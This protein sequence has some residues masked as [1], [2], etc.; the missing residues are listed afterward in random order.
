MARK[1]KNKNSDQDDFEIKISDDYSDVVD[2]V[3]SENTG[4]YVQEDHLPD[5]EFTLENILAEYKGSAFIDG[6]KRTPKKMLQEKTDRIILEQM[7]TDKPD[8]T[9][10]RPTTGDAAQEK[11]TDKYTKSDTQ[12]MHKDDTVVRSK[13]ES[14]RTSKVKVNTAK[15]PDIDAVNKA[16]IRE[17]QTVKQDENESV[18]SGDTEI[19]DVIAFNSIAG[20]DDTESD[21]VRDIEQAIEQ[22]TEYELETKKA[23]KKV[24]G[25]FSRNSGEMPADDDEYG[26]NKE[27]EIPVEVFEDVY[28]EEPE[29]G[30]AIKKFAEKCNIFSMKC[31]LSFVLSAILAILTLVF[32]ADVSLPFGIGHNATVCTGILLILL[33]GIMLISA[34]KLVN[35]FTDIMKGRQ[36][37]D[38]LNL[39][40]CLATIAAG[41]FSMMIKDTTI[42]MPFCVVSAF[43]LT[44]TLWGE[45]IYFRALTETLK[46]VQSTAEPTGIV[47]T[48]CHDINRAAIK[49]ITSKTDGF[50]NNLIQADITE[51]VFKYATPILIV[52][53]A[54]FAFFSSFGQ[55]QSHYFTHNFA[56]IMA[57]AA[58][59]S[60]L[61]AYAVPFYAVT[62][63]ARQSGA[64]VA[65]WGGADE[66]VHSD[67]A[68][69]KDEDIFPA[70]TVSLGGIKIFEEVPPDK[71]LR[72]TASLI[73]ASRSVLASLFMQ[74]LSK[75]GLTKLNVDDFICYEGGI[76][77]TIRGER[78]ITGSAALMNLQGIRVPASLNMKNGVFTAIDKKLIAVFTIEYVPVKTVQNALVS[79]LRHHVKLLFSVRDFNITPLMLE[80][81]FKVPVE[82]VEYIPIQDSYDLSDDTKL[83]T[84][85]TA[86]VLTREGLGPYV[87]AI[88]GGRRLRFTAL[89]ATILTLL[90][91]V[92][93][94]VIMYTICMTGAFSAGSAGNLLLYMLSMMAIVLVVCGFARYRQ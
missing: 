65:G 4:N 11:Y 57:A 44:F 86:A 68:S 19:N 26:Y 1:N 82:D 71:A 33:F 92:G 80:Q 74:L 34:E 88:I 42:G 93:G 29:F 85:R 8:R 61:F 13:T 47:V 63:R 67:G 59:F 73:V 51:T 3:V 36:G 94:M 12:Q 15:L 20:T 83:D 5:D 28:V 9:I 39:F 52:A 6:D 49:K 27:N 7:A 90:T 50:Y 54:T 76:G 25:I 45:S 21:I 10:K 77:G 69:I 32:E 70:G 89:A 46:T 40:S 64:A 55:G 38:T 17:Y 35:G 79:I 48:M 41:I 81:K 37:I 56:A 91:T 23:A 16:K 2:T 66:L 87:E 72:Y 31:F 43:S 78:V 24:F 62:R 22:Q 60:A 14:G 30:S 75:Q 84:K 58:P 18:T 53:A